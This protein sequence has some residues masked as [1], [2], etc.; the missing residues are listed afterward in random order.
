MKR[1]GLLISVLF[2]LL[3]VE[4]NNAQ[5]LACN[6]LIFVSLD[7]NCSYTLTPDDVL[8]G[9]ILSNCV[10]EL[11]KTPPFGN[12]PWVPAVLSQADIG[13][14][15]LVRVT[16]IP[17]G[18]SC[19]GN[20]SCEDKL[21]PVLICNGLST[22]N[23][24]GGGPVSVATSDLSITTYD[25]C[26]A[27]ILTPATLQYDCS[28]LGVNTVQLTATDASGNTSMCMHTVLVAN[29]SSCQTC[30]S[31]C[32]ES[33]SV[34]YDEG[35]N[36]LLPAFQSN[37][38]SAFDVYGDAQFDA[39][40]TPLDST[41][42]IDY[43]AGTAGYNWFTRQWLWITG[44]GQF[45]PCEQTVVFPAT[46][47]VTVQG[48]IYID[49]SD[50]CV[51]D[52]GEQGVG[53]YKV[54]VTKLP[55]G[56][57]QTIYPLADGTYSADIV[58]SVQDTA[59]QLSL[60][61]PANVNPVC[62]TALIIPNST[63]TPSYTF[64]IGLQTQGNCPLMQ[65]DLGDLFMRRCATNLLTLKYC[66][67]GLD[68]AY[69]AF[70]TVNLDS[71]ID[72]QSATLPYTVSGPDKLYTF[73]LGDVP[74]FF[75]GSIGLYATVSCDA[76]SG[77]TLCNEANIYPDVPCNGGWLGAE[78]TASAECSGDSVSLT[79]RNKGMQD[80]TAPLNYIVVEDFIM[81]HDA[82]FQLNAG[83]TLTMKMP[84]NGSTWRI[85]SDQIPGFPAPGFVAAAVEGCGGLVS[86]GYINIFGYSDNAISYDQ[87]C[88]VVVASCDPNDKTAIPV[89]LNDEHI[90]RPNQ[91]IDYKIRFQN[92]GSDTAF[93]VVVVD[94]LSPLLD[95]R[96]LEIGASSHPYHLEIYPGGILHFVFQPIAL[97][98]SN[99][100]EV[101]SHGYLK[102]KIRQ[103]P[104]LP[105]GTVIENTAAIYFDQNAPVF[106]N[107]AFHTIGYPFV[108]YVPLS[109][110]A[111]ALAPGCN[112]ASD[113]AIT[114][115]AA[116]GIPP[117][118]FLWNNPDLQG[119][120]LTGLPAGNYLVTI[121]D[122]RG[123]TLAESIGLTEPAP[124][125][126][127]MNATET[128]GNENNGTATATASGGTSPY[129]Y[130]WNTGATTDSIS[131]LSAGA[132]SV[133][134]TDAHGCSQSNSVA[135]GQLVNTGDPDALS[136]IQVW[137]NP[138]HDRIL[139]DLREVL[140]E[141]LR[142]DMLSA[143]GRLLRQIGSDKLQ[144]FLTL[145]LG[146]DPGAGFVLLVLHG[147]DGHVFTEKI[148][149]R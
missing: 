46:H 87:E 8:E 130:I 82:D 11:D 50:D 86:T 108:P 120:T 13:K 20:V 79:L 121:T 38:W 6:D 3:F 106:T 98:D 119:D 73:Q 78:I 63:G 75:S 128:I 103:Q 15:Y 21:P 32:P 143:D 91:P 56:S 94:T 40:C 52:A 129:T 142:I 4:K 49:A 25:A 76:V 59:A 66:N 140:P 81:V 39:A 67:L 34:D 77:Q 93:K 48:Q 134:V 107:T 145:D 74:P 97:P 7:E 45:I 26:S 105:D 72:L 84:A 17:S 5:V 68:T 148:V 10:V 116:G 131:G 147:L 29:S 24:N 27:A 141:L 146:N 14:T 55:S 102:F 47:T 132:Y 22:I 64:D 139:L 85:E 57:T 31:E 104:D 114:I 112:G 138:A 118:T 44:S 127:T 9:T 137:P 95:P 42:F 124:V 133:I 111:Q 60:S 53:H 58:F 62:P 1:I 54:V 30:V 37:N 28:D 115:A 88:G 35:N 90:I 100:N 99:V 92:T 126:V 19:W 65:V 96:T 109:Y 51:Y 89:G 101:E 69:G 144:P 16:H 2:F 110:S 36:N 136:R 83:Q 117:Y 23:L 71:L 123:G 43:Q 61:L 149:I 70:V 18:N 41:Y 80:M 33:V 122:S 135:V 12:G 125:T 113:G